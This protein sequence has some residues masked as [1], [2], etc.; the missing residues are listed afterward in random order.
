NVGGVNYLTDPQGERYSGWFIDAGKNWYYFNESDKAMK[1]G[2]HH[3]SEDGYW[4]YL[5]PADGKMM[6]GWQTID[7]KEYFFQPVR[8]TGNYYFGNEEEKWRYSLN[9]NIP[10]GA[11]YVNTT[12]L[13]GSV[14]D[15]N[16]A[17]ISNNGSQNRENGWVQKDGNTYYYENGHMILNTWKTIGGKNYYFG[18]NGVMLINATTPDGKY[19]GGDGAYVQEALSQEQVKAIYQQKL[20]Q[21]NTLFGSSDYYEANYLIEDFN[22]DGILDLLLFETRRTGSKSSSYMKAELYTVAN[23]ALVLCDTL[24]NEDMYVGFGASRKNGDVLVN[25]SASRYSDYIYSITSSLNFMKEIY[26]TTHGDAGEYGE[27]YENANHI[28]KDCIHA[29]D[30]DEGTWINMKS[31]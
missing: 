4:Y 17:K 27:I 16:G 2:W 19:V 7:G 21:C 3:D 12:T 15:E 26:Y 24:V 10:Y 14:V 11:M 13:D 23:G 25:F 6:D 5:N 31:L 22:K 20:N 18:S 30:I 9:G 28:Y 1:T 29:T 8:N